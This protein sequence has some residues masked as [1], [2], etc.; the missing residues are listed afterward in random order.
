MIV[1]SNHECRRK[2]EEPIVLSLPFTERCYV[3]PHC[4]TKLDRNTKKEADVRAGFLT[5]KVPSVATR[6]MF[7]HNLPRSFWPTAL[8]A[9][10]HPLSQKATDLMSTPTHKLAHMNWT[11]RIRL[12][13]ILGWSTTLIISVYNSDLTLTLLSAAFITFLSA[14]ESAHTGQTMT[15]HKNGVTPEQVKSATKA[16]PQRCDHFLGYL[17]QRPKNTPIPNECL[18]C[19]DTLKCLLEN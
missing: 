17:R 13:L 18:T 1:C 3:C 16:S 5:P 8:K 4:F 7:T 11:N 12:L 14:F 10:L 6:V 9:L 19:P 2:I 15:A